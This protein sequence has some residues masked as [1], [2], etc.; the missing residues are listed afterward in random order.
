VPH[1]LSS[2]LHRTRTGV[3]ALLLVVLPLQSVGQLV[4]GLQA[5]R[6]LHTGLAASGSA[7]AG[8]GAAL[9][10]VLDRL[11]A[12][13]DPRLQAA[14][15]MWQPSRGPAAGLH[16]HGGVF[17]EHAGDTVDVLDVADPADASQPGGA[18]AFL[19]WLPG[20]LTLPAP[21]AGRGHPPG[22][23][24]DWRDRVVA[25]PLAPPRG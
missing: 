25:P 20:A 7:L 15:P 5:H 11:H 12:A 2:L 6:H 22:A 17:H 9:R 13:Q 14:R 3:L 8:L 4:A 18:T 23:E 10:T 19:T 16:A 21:A 24:P 1:F